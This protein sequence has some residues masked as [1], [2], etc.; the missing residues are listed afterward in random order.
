MPYSWPQGVG[1]DGACIEASWTDSLQ[2]VTQPTRRRI[3]L[4]RW[5]LSFGVMVLWQTIY[6]AIGRDSESWIWKALSVYAYTLLVAFGF[7]TARDA[8]RHRHDPRPL[9]KVAVARPRV[10]LDAD[11]NRM[12]A[13]DGT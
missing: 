10:Y 6:V 4:W 2:S 1:V 9:R 13:P 11:G 7:L 8:W 12:P 5:R 3:N